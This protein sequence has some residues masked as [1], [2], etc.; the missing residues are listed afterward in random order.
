MLGSLKNSIMPHVLP[1]F[2]LQWASLCSRNRS[3]QIWMNGRVQ[4]CRWVERRSPSTR[5]NAELRLTI[6]LGQ[7]IL[8]NCLRNVDGCEHVRDQSDG[9][10]DRKTTDGSGAEQK[11]EE[12]RHDGR[13]VRIDDG[14]KRLV[15]PG[16][17]RGRRRFAVAQL[18]ADAFEH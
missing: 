13:H 4:K 12:G 11:E 7:V 17:D 2:R 10:S 6:H 9:Q 16:L 14:Q 8:E 5:S 15:E 3:V 1:F 18:L